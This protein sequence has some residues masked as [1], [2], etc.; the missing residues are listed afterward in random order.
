MLA[1]AVPWVEEAIAMRNAVE[2][3]TGTAAGL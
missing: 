1:E 2:H 3:P